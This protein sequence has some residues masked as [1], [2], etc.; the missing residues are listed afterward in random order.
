M[1]ESHGEVRLDLVCVRMGIIDMFCEVFVHV[2]YG[3]VV[4]NL[5]DWY[6]L[7]VKQFPT[8][9]TY[10]QSEKYMSSYRRDEKQIRR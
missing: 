2:F 10:R 8:R 1:G 3:Y 9:L 5:G 4:H 7:V 6:R